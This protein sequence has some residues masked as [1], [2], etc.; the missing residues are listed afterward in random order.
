MQTI[1]EKERQLI[2]EK[3]K[4]HLKWFRRFWVIC[5]C[6]V[7]LYLIICVL[8]R[9]YIL[10]PRAMSG[11]LSLSGQIYQLVQVVF[12]ASALL[13][14][15]TILMIKRIYWRELARY[16]SSPQRVMTRFRDGLFILAIICDT[17]AILGLLIFL[18]N[19]QLIMMIAFGLLALFYYAHIYPSEDLVMPHINRLLE[20]T[21]PEHKL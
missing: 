8:V 4:M 9:E 21:Y 12:F 10:Y 20:Q 14:Y 15:P 5:L 17:V 7:P 3:S 16:T 6:I 18:F 2:L 13:A 11:F 1:E 19:G